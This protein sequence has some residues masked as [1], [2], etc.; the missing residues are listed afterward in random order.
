LKNIILGALGVIL[1][2]AK[3]V[4]GPVFDPEIR[5]QFARESDNIRVIAF[6]KSLP[7]RVMEGF[8]PANRMQQQMVLMK[9]AEIVQK[10]TL[11]RLQSAADSGAAV[12]VT[13][14]WIAN[15]IIIDMPAAGLKTLAND[16][17]ILWVAANHKIQLIQ[18]GNGRLRN[19][20]EAQS[21]TYGLQKIASPEL[22][23]K[24]GKVIGTGVT[25]GILDTGIDAT[26]P[27]LKD[28]KVLFKDFAGKSPT[29]VDGHGHGTHVAGTISGLNASG[30]TIGVAPGVN[31]VIGRILDDNGSG[32][33]A[34]ILEGMQWIADPDGNPKTDDAPKLVSNSWGGG[35]SSASKNP[36]DE[37][38]CKATL[39]WEKLNILPVFAAGNSG[40]KPSTVLLPGACPNAL[41][42]GAT[43]AEDVIAS[44]SSRGPVIWKSGTIVKPDLVAPGVK[45][46]SSIPKGQYAEWS[47]TSMATPHVAGVAAL[48][49][50]VKPDLKVADAKKFLLESADAKPAVPNNDY[51][52]GR[53]NALKAVTM[54]A[55]A[56]AAVRGGRVA[57]PARR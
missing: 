56:A 11:Q 24:S 50:Q 15:A 53:L 8:T 45:V 37:P 13:P 17:N 48:L 43:D 57:I 51:G 28:K 41:T 5:R 36:E 40:S 21:Y 18:P 44:F 27:D 31:L 12:K 7:P 46:K 35:G 33:W 54:A 2:G 16:N 22:R 26:H 34:G 20:R 49:Y 30:T 25:V 39:N 6:M 38:L 47:G 52:H 9:E 3:A 1:L 10:S 29:P 42:V 23:Q 14:L 32:S 19:F 4:G 55:T